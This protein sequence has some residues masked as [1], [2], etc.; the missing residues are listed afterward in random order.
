MVNWLPHGLSGYALNVSLENSTIGEIVSVSYP[1]WS[2]LNNTT[3]LPSDHIRISAVD[4]GRI[5][6]AGATNVPL[7]TLT[8]RGD[9]AGTSAILVD[10]VRMDADGGSAIISLV[11]NG[12]IEV[13]KL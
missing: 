13:K 3:A 7:A 1:T 12:T 5:I 6:N 8:I 9:S 11:A 2:I 4:L 10:T